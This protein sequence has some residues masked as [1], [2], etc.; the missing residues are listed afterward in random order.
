MRL[1]DLIKQ[2]DGQNDPII[3]IDNEGV[4]M[5]AE[6]IDHGVGALDGQVGDL[7]ILAPVE[8]EG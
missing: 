5:T 3:A 7:V 4:V 1:S 6:I 8:P 2:C